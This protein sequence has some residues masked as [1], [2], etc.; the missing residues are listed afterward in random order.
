MPQVRLDIDRDKVAELNLSL[1]DV[2]LAIGASLGGLCVNEFNKFGRQYNV[3]IQA[4]GDYT[5]NP[6]DIN[7]IFVRSRNNV[8]IPISSIATIK[9]KV[10]PSLRPDLICIA[11]PILAGLQQKDSPRPKP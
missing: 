7:K 8:M 9:K 1:V 4:A 6:E 10:G 11:L 2:N 3:L 5:L